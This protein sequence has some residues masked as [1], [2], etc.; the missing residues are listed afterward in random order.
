[1]IAYIINLTEIN[2]NKLKK[3]T[4]INYIKKLIKAN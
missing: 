4:L 2:K 3:L 1:M